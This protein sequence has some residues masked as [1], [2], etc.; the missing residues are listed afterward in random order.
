MLGLD[1]SQRH[2][3]WLDHLEH[4]WQSGGTMW[5]VGY[6]NYWMRGWWGPHNAYLAVLVFY[7]VFGLIVYLAR[8]LMRRPLLYLRLFISRSFFKAS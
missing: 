7:G 2:R 8:P 4:M 5:G 6:F 3:I 1:P